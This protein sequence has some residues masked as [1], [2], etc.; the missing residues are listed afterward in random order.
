MA[1]TAPRPQSIWLRDRWVIAIP[2][3]FAL[4]FAIS[5]GLFGVGASTAAPRAAAEFSSPSS[6][7]AQPAVSATKTN[8]DWQ[9]ALGAGPRGPDHI[10]DNCGAHHGGVYHPDYCHECIKKGETPVRPPSP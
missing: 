6:R 5:F 10:C 4:L 9:S 3:A 7:I 1:G 8:P 2:V